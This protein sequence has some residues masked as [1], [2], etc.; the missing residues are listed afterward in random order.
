MYKINIKKYKW[1]FDD[2]KNI[3]NKLIKK[4]V[5]W[6]I[7]KEEFEEL[8]K[9][10]K[11]VFSYVDEVR[12]KL[13]TIFSEPIKE[14]LWNW[15]DNIVYNYKSNWVI[16]I[17][18][19]KKYENFENL[20]NYFKHKYKLLKKTIWEF[21]PDTY[22]FEWE[23]INP[24]PINYNNLEYYQVKYKTIYTVQRKVKWYTLNDLPS[25][26]RNN[27]RLLEQLKILYLKYIKTKLYM[28]Y[29]EYKT[30]KNIWN[31]KFKM[32][33][34]E[35][36]NKVNIDDKILMSYKT[37]NI[38]YDIEKD[39][40]FLIDFD[41]GNL[42]KQTQEIFDKVKKIDKQEILDVWWKIL[43]EIKKEYE[44][45]TPKNL[46]KFFKEYVKNN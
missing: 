44:K 38:M 19:R 46:E 10:N 8:K 12:S 27:W 13:E 9:L 14:S 4:R 25:D 45:L 34:W 24:N 15:Q 31:L 5:E 7:T 36:S 18:T 32:D 30:Y 6:N 29:I 3:L 40:L 26:I 16:K 37:P 42:N 21:I 11:S 43:E 2:D 41:T 1:D 28:H 17:M 23:T 33:I 22:F 35:L 20:V 39:R